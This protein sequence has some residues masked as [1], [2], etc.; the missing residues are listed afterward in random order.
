M[1]HNGFYIQE[2]HMVLNLKFIPDGQPDISSLDGVPG[3]IIFPGGGAD[4]WVKGIVVIQEIPDQKLAIHAVDK[5]VIPPDI[6]VEQKLITYFRLG[7]GF[8][9][10][11]FIDIIGPEMEGQIF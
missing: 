7:I 6:G 10:F 2:A 4:A 8:N 9:R 5:G 11:N 3:G 1:K